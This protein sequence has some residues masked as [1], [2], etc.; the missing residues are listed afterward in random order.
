MNFTKKQ[1]LF[2]HGV[3]F[4]YVSNQ[5][6]ESSTRI[7]VEKIMDILSEDLLDGSQTASYQK[8]KFD[9]DDDL[10]ADFDR[11]EN[12]D[13]FTSLS[14]LRVKDSK[15]NRSYVLQF[16]RTGPNMLCF[17]LYEGDNIVDTVYDVKG[18]TR[19]GTSLILHKDDPKKSY[20]YTVSK[21]PKDW[22]LQLPVGKKFVL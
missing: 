1:K 21:F 3:L 13:L 14:D 8:F 17:D 6:V 5:E 12:M 11:I 19:Q 18:V 15:T 9:D 7:N 20:L 4:H 10:D 16:I 2:L 22:T